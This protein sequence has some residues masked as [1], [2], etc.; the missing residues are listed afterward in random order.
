MF[1]VEDFGFEDGNELLDV[2][3]KADFTL[4]YS[5]RHTFEAGAHLKRHT[6]R[7]AQEFANWSYEA[8][9]IT[10]YVPSVYAQ[11]AWRPWPFLT[12]Q[13]GVRASHFTAD[14]KNPDEDH[15]NFGK[16]ASYFDVDPRLTV[17]YQVGDNTF[18]KGAYGRYTQYVFRVPREMQGISVMSDIWFTVDAS[19][20]PQHSN[21]Y[22]AG[23]ETKLLQDVDITAEIYY[24]DYDDIGEFDFRAEA[25]QS[26]DEALL[27]GTGYSYGF[28]TNI[29][30]R[31]G[32]HLGW[33]SYSF[34]WTIRNVEGIKLVNENDPDSPTQDY[35]PK[36]DQRHVLNT[37][38]SYDLTQRWRLNARYAFASG[39]G[40]TETFGHAAIEGPILKWDPQYRDY[41][42]ASRIP[43]YSRF[44]VGIRGRFEGWGVTWMPFL[45]IVNVL[46]HTNEFNRFSSEGAWAAAEADAE[47]ATLDS[48]NQLPFLPTI[49]IDLEF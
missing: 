40:Y 17:R 31:A 36:Y 26:T 19:R 14:N 33:I 8:F 32:R 6:M 10:A 21:H 45:Q 46:N 3:A 47:Y 37:V 12:I 30:K 44:D 27:S 16:T 48:F 38:Y 7:L 28:D 2:D 18:L 49:G 35:Y 24:K 1:E 13:P 20:G 15:P 43:Y 5:E 39:Q 29:K 22:I 25:P 9:D 34:G 41:L 23:F 42:N 11:D 4:F